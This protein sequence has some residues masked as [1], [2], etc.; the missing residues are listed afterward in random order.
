M[1]VNVLSQKK[2]SKGASLLVSL[3]LIFVVLSITGC[4]VKQPGQVAIATAHP[5]ATQAG[6]EILNKGG[7][8][9]DAA[10][11]V[12]AALA[13]VEP[14]G[15][16]LG[17]GGF[18]L[19]HR[20]S[21]GLD[22]ML[23]G[24][25][26]APLAAD[27]NMFIDAQ[28]NAV[29]GLSLNGALAAGIPGM[30]AG[31]VH[32]SKHYGKLSLAESLGPAIRYAEQGFNIGE[33]H[34]KLL[35]FRKT[36]L[37]KDAETA[38]I[39]L[40]QGAI[41]EKGSLLVQTDLANTLKQ[42][43]DKGHAGFYDGTVANKLV[44]AVQKNAG[45]WS[46]ADLQQ[47]Q[48]V[49]RQPIKGTYKGIKITSAALPSSGGIV[50]VEAL[51]ILENL[52]LDSVDN[53]TR[54]HLIVE[55][56]RRAYHDRA[57]YL[58]DTD[59][60]DVPVERLLNKDYAQGLASTLRADKALPSDYL[61]GQT[62]EQPGG[63]NT[64]HFSIIDAE[65]NRVSATLSVN[66][67]FGAGLVASGTGVLLNNEMDDFASAKNSANGYGLVGGAANAIAPEKRMLSSMTPTF[68][69]DNKRIAV[70]GTPGGSR[71]ISMVLLAALDF[72]EGNASESWVNVKRF[73]HQYIP[74]QILYEKNGLTEDEVQGLQA[75]G[76]QL[77]QKY[78]YGNMQAVQLD[79]VSKELAA[80]SDP[81]G[82]GFASVQ[83]VD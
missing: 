49:E 16:G 79:K 53:I 68:L 51:N 50:L 13:V 31:L 61:T 60:I 30:P 82:E 58:G 56:L 44:A 47:Y 26:K 12:S 71:I 42:L 67:P 69:E 19:L 7:N 35:G 9:Y 70:L 10:V 15:S 46:L 38:A 32:L 81:R 59:F 39:F 6:F 57:L 52:D 72:A 73:H 75:L 66:F 1:R 21:D 78:N 80:A 76:H 4:S 2:S 28:G 63:R 77:M 27:K 41:P 8:V 33:R 74:D 25:E 83:T 36:I 29:T 40:Q 22:I 5:L 20:E 23:D 3:T 65:G 55:A 45:I 24:R 17:G 11:A 18:W 37:N 14:S 48:V 34:Q 54:K 43:A 64:T 62:E